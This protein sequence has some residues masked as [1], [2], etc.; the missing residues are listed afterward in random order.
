MKVLLV[1]DSDRL[2]ATLARGL[3]ASGFSVDTAN[4]GVA[5]A[6]YLAAF[7]YDLVILDINL[8]R[9]DGFGVLR[10]IPD[11]GTRP[12]VLALSARDQIDDRVA[13][14]NAGADDYMVKPF[15]FEELVARL[16]ALARR[17]L[18][19]QASLLTCGDLTLDPRSHV[20][21]CNGRDL[22]LT[23][24]EFALLELLLRNR[25]RVF[26]R[27]AILERLTGSETNVSDRSIEV[28]VFGLRRKLE[29]LGRFDLVRNKRGVGYV[30]D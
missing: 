13:A 2:R 14:L 22:A 9:M 20:A 23:P 4:D 12:R 26:S 28:L 29:A 17:P 15:A 8:P 30:I 6:G 16:H 18:Q 25:G 11:H 10:E 7:E 1:E 3:C 5:A 19:A 24:R 27:G 21:S